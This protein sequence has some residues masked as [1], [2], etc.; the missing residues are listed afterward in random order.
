MR[1]VFE[2]RHVALGW[3]QRYY[4]HRCCEAQDC[5]YKTASVQHNE[6]KKLNTSINIKQTVGVAG[7]AKFQ[8]L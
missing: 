2:A 7:F 5:L 1:N 4:D 8:N 6:L 3:K